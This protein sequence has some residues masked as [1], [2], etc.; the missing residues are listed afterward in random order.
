[1][2]RR[3]SSSFPRAT[4]REATHRAARFSLTW[5][6]PISNETI[7][8]RVTHTRDY[9]RAGQDHIEIETT[10]PKR[11]PLPITGSGYRSHFIEAI[12]LINAGGPVTF[13]NAW[14]DREAKDKSWVAAETAKTQG[15]LFRWADAQRG[16]TKRKTNS[17]GHTPECGKRRVVKDPDHIADLEIGD[18]QIRKRMAARDRGKPV[19]KPKGVE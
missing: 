16:A 17:S 10:K 13:V 9:L 12:E 6:N 11:A 15:D 2:P 5:Q 14:I 7:D 3:T 19:A 4:A 8:I 1:M 18:G